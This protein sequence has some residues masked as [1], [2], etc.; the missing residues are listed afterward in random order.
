MVQKR[1]KLPHKLDPAEYVMVFLSWLIY[2][3]GLFFFAESGN[4]W[5]FLALGALPVLVTAWSLGMGFG[6]ASAVVSVLINLLVH[7]NQHGLDGSPNAMALEYLAGFA[8]LTLTGMFTGHLKDL[9]LRS[10]SELQSLSENNQKLIQLSQA[11]DAINQMAAD[12]IRSEDWMNRI[13]DLLLRIGIAS[14]C[15]HLILFKL[16]GS[17]V[18]HYTGL[19]YHYWPDT[20][21]QPPEADQKPIPEELNTWI[22]IRLSSY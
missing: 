15:D 2:L 19:L 22:K 13:P 17:G 6:T 8:L 10:S 12:L 21:L 18:N 9:Q 5:I 11:L 20:N 4:S 14:G 3:I 1:F 7:I 16:T